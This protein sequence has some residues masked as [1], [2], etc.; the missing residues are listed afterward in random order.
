VLAVGRIGA[1]AHRQDG[2]VGPWAVV[3][4]QRATAIDG[5]LAVFTQ[6]VLYGNELAGLPAGLFADGVD[7]AAG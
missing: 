1:A 2:T 5:Q 3:I 6:L 7:G 4:A